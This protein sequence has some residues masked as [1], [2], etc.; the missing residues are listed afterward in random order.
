ML[1]GSLGWSGRHTLGLLALGVA[2]VFFRLTEA[3]CPNQSHLVSRHLAG[4]DAWL[5][6]H[7][8][9]ACWG[10][11]PLHFECL[12]APDGALCPNCCSFHT[13]N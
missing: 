4:H 12:G 5:L 2:L 6:S 3:R 9:R 1:H 11:K 10:A 7:Y 8:M 13:S